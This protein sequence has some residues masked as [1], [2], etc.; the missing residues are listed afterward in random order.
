MSSAAAAATAMA[1]AMGI[2]ANLLRVLC[3]RCAKRLTDSRNVEGR[4][5]CMLT[6]EIPA[7]NRELTCTSIGIWR[8]ATSTKCDY[9]TDQKAKCEVV[10][11]F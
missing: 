10:S 5:G 3:I 1:D 9:C 4:V 11:A 8:A 7:C 6:G 2:D